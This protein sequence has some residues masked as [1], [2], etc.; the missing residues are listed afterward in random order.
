MTRADATYNARFFAA[1]L[2]PRYWRKAPRR[3]TP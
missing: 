1:A 2:L 3:A